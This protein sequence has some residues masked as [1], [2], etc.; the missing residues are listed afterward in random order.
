[1]SSHTCRHRT[2]YH[3]PEC[4]RLTLPSSGPAFGGPLKSNV[5]A[6]PRIPMH[7]LPKPSL[8]IERPLRFKPSSGC[9]SFGGQRTAACASLP[10]LFARRPRSWSLR[11]K[12]S[13]SVLL[14]YASSTRN[15]VRSEHFNRLARVHGRMKVSSTRVLFAGRGL[16]LPVGV[17]AQRRFKLAVLSSMRSNPSFK[18]TCLRQSA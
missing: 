5:R 1:M 6:H 7:S 4:R 2:S 16:S 9:P 12:C 18:R 15:R 14:V 8:A 13:K 11:I 3:A 10:V 17:T